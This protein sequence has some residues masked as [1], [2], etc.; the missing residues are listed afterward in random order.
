[1]N[2]N[3]MDEEIFNQPKTQGF[4]FEQIDFCTYEISIRSSIPSSSLTFE[5]IR[6][7]ETTKENTGLKYKPRT[8]RVA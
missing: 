7:T 8:K 1:M 2:K 4:C 6:S 5:I 3:S